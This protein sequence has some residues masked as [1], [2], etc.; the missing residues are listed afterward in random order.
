MDENTAV[1]AVVAAFSTAA[2]VVIGAITTAYIKI[3]QANDAS[4]KAE[5]ALSKEHAKEEAVTAKAQ[6]K[7]I[8]EQRADLLHEVKGFYDGRLK[9]I[10][11]ELEKIEKAHMACREENAGIKRD[12][13]AMQAENK[14]QA[15]EI[16]SLRGKIKA[17]EAA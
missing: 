16:T 10:A 6:Q 12:I 9:D 15:E 3:R 4:A 14:E 1:G 11:I 17:L 7:W 13:A 5:M 8:N 2:V